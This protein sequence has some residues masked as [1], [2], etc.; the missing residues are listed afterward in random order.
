MVQA[1]SPVEAR[2]PQAVAQE[3][4]AD[5]KQDSSH[6]CTD[7]TDK[8]HRIFGCR[9]TNAHRTN[10]GAEKAATTEMET[11]LASPNRA[12]AIHYDTIFVSYGGMDGRQAGR[13]SRNE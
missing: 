13:G 3:I 1:P 7:S 12:T 10:A 2:E 5:H 4:V 9:K 11:F 8:S 6:G